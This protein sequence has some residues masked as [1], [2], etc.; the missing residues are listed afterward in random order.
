MT[1][2]TSSVSAPARTARPLRL[3]VLLQD[4][5]FGGTQRYALHLLRSLDRSLFTPELWVLN[6]G[7]DLVDEAL[8]TGVPLVRISR[9]PPGSP[10]ALPPLFARI[11]R[12][13]PDILY[14]LTVVP[15]IWGRLFGR[16]LGVPAIAA[17][18][19]TLRPRQWEPL[20]WRCTNRLICNAEM[21]RT[22]AI[23]ELGVPPERVAVVPNCVDTERFRPAPKRLD[24]PPCIVSVSRLV[25]DKSPLAM[26]E[27]F[28]LVRR[29]TP[30]ARLTLVGDG[31]LRLQVEAR[32]SALGLT[33]AVEIITG[34]GEVRPHLAQADVFALASRREGS[35]NAIL[36]AM[37]AG[38]P[39]VASRTGGIPDLVDHGST[40][41]LTVPENPADLAQAL[42]RLL[43]NREL[44]ASMGAAGR[45]KAVRAHSPEAMA[46]ATEAVL[47]DAWAQRRAR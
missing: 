7:E 3:A 43:T 40:G 8:A 34:C 28:A 47:L 38:L 19:R 37:A 12:A 22:R 42:V 10:L 18:F 9:R 6:A 41:F 29:Q 11:A 44:C 17:G 16:A 24:G 13:K 21:L 1:Q 20:L 2:T 26:V 31:P 46:R 36:E 5:E 45:D 32:L 33:Q 14:T 35:P 30:E 23:Q 15:N 39:V 25:P 4:L 27:A